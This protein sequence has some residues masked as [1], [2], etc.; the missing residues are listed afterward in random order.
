MV[1][2][3]IHWPDTLDGI[4][5]PIAVPT[6][7]QPSARVEFLKRYLSVISS[8]PSSMSIHARVPSLYVHCQLVWR[9]PD[10]KPA[11]ARFITSSER[12]ASTV[13]RPFQLCPPRSS[14]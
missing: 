3:L 2:G 4:P 14:M 8:L 7:K 13:P 5:E 9:Q 1:V 10:R 11:R 12:V 6:G